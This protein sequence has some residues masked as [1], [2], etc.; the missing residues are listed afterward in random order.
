[1]VTKGVLKDANGKA[2]TKDDF[3]IIFKS[4]LLPEGPYSVLGS[5]PPELKDAIKTAFIDMPKKD[6]AAFASLS[7]G[8]DIEFA[9]HQRRR[10]RSDR[11]HGQVQR[12]PAQ[13]WL[14][15]NTASGAGSKRFRPVSLLGA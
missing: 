3:R 7:D 2:L 8:K 15:T 1:M 4:P 14:V 13:D 9:P 11:R 10:L 12:R 5:L 6:K